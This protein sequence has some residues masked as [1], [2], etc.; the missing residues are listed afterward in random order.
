MSKLEELTPNAAVRDILPDGLV[1]VVS[2]RWFGSEA[3]EL[4]GRNFLNDIRWMGRVRGLFHS[5]RALSKPHK[6]F[7]FISDELDEIRV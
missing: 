6:K 5:V 2:V 4:K 1:T 3:I 7:S